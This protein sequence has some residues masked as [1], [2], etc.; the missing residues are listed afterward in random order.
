MWFVSMNI[1]SGTKLPCIVV[2]PS[3]HVVV[4]VLSDEKATP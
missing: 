4:T 3:E 1:V 2:S